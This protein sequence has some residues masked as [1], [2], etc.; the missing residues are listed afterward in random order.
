MS[1]LLRKCGSLDVSQPYGPPQSV[2]GIALPI[3][4]TYSFQRDAAKWLAVCIA[5]V[6]AESLASTTLIFPRESSLRHDDVRFYKY[7]QE[8]GVPWRI[9]TGS[10]LDDWIYWHIL[11]Q[12]LLFT[13]IY[14]ATANLPISQVTRKRYPFPDNGFITGTITWNHYEIFLPFLVQSLRNADPPELDPI[15]QFQFPSLCCTPLYAVVFP[16]SWLFYVHTRTA[17]S[18][19]IRLTYIDAARSTHKKKITPRRGPTENIRLPHF[20]YCCVTSPP[21]SEPA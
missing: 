19:G 20:L 18:L 3:A 15:L 21:T 4:R 17:V 13:I 6:G 1:R 8:S 11:L 10:G 14:I 2:S 5:S 16:V 7:C 9:I 12:F